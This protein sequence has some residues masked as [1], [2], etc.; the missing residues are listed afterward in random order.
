MKILICSQ[1]PVLRQMAGDALAE[2]GLEAALARECCEVV[3]QIDLAAVDLVVL[4]LDYRGKDAWNLVEWLVENHPLIPI[5]FL[6]G[7]RGGAECAL[8]ATVSVTLE[9]PVPAAQLMNAVHRLL[10][11]PPSERLNDNFRQR[12]A[13][14][15]SRPFV[16]PAAT[17]PACSSGWGIND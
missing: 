9:K 4:D 16:W 7:A 8:I 10:D 13:L 1:D 5:V 2:G 17:A 6:L 14:R 12:M 11:E 15:Y 3:D